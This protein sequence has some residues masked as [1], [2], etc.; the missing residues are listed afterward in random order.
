MV[1]VIH[2]ILVIAFI[3]TTAFAGSMGPEIRIVDNKVSIQAESIP[4]SR[5]IQLLDRAIGTTS[6]VPPQYATR[7]VN[8]QFSDLDLSDAVHKIFEGQML[9]YVFIDGQGIVVTA[10]SQA[11]GGATVAPPPREL[12]PF[13]ESPTFPPPQGF[14]IDP[15]TGSPVA[16]PQNGIP[17]QP[18]P[19]G[20]NQVQPAV[21]QTPF[22]PL[23]N[24]RA[25]QQ[26]QNLPGN[27][28]VPFGG[29][30]PFGN[31]ASPFGGAVVG[32]AVTPFGTGGNNPSAS[33]SVPNAVAPITT[34]PLVVPNQQPTKP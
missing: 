26:Q 34:S 25:N 33:Q 7:S 20:G 19:F 8:V 13:Q 17:G 30:T 9:D 32:G 16:I 4:L 21:I 29:A 12:S 18:V 14:T 5:L 27:Q 28:V 31:A 6:T 23:A 24:P 10:A 2:L 1:Q 15:V 3:S 22:G 11:A